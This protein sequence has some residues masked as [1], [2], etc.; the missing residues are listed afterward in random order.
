M[1]KYIIITSFLLASFAFWGITDSLQKLGISR[2][3]AYHFIYDSFGAGNPQLPASVTK[4]AMKERLKIVEDGLA[5]VKECTKSEDFT[6]WWTQYRETMKPAPPEPPKP[7][8]V[9]RAEQMAEIQRQYSDL[10]KKMNDAPEDQKAIYKQNLDMMRKSIDQMAQVPHEQD[11]D[12][13]V[14]MRQ[15]FAQGIAEYQGKVAAWEKEYPLDPQPF[16]KKRL[17]EYLDLVKTVDFSAELR[18]DGKVKKFTDPAYESKSWLWKKCYRAGKDANASAERI[19]RN[20]ISELNAPS[21]T[22]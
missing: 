21:P 20:W 8:E 10:E 14:Y 7:M 22:H 9:V 15:A 17:Q 3:E 11:S 1:K 19:V 18:T 6:R 4:I 12:M 16:I 13:N 5:L 2:D